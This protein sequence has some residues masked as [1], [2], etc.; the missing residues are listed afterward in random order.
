MSRTEALQR[1]L[2]AVWSGADTTDA[3]CVLDHIRDAGFDVVWRPG[4]QVAAVNSEYAGARSASRDEVGQE[5]GL[6]VESFPAVTS[7]DAG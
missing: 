5:R 7:G 1:A 2:S 3:E 4:L 6:Q